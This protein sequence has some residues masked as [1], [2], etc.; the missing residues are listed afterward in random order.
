MGNPIE[1]G[2]PVVYFFRE[3]FLPADGLRLA[4]D[5]AKNLVHILKLT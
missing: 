1:T 2:T 4:E 3:L 5:A